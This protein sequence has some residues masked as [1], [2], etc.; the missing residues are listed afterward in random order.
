MTSEY[1]CNVVRFLLGSSAARS[2]LILFGGGAIDTLEANPCLSCSRIQ[3]LEEEGVG[4]VG[5]CLL[6]KIVMW[7]DVEKVVCDMMITSNIGKR[8]LKSHCIKSCE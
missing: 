2:H 7:L 3:V 5:L 8:C 4:A 6:P 1:I